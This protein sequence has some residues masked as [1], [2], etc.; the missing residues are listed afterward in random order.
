MITKPELKK[1]NIG[2]NTCTGSCIGTEKQTLKSFVLFG[3]LL[4]SEYSGVFSMIIFDDLRGDSKET[5]IY[6]IT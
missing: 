5:V 4:C 1:E 2:T 3:Y 6:I